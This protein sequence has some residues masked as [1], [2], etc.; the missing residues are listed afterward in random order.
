MTLLLTNFEFRKG[1]IMYQVDL[2]ANPVF[3]PADQAV[4]V[5]G[6]GIYIQ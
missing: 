6:V 2:V 5:A 1:G 4:R 3:N